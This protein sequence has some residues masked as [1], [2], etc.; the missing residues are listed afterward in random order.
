MNS[1]QVAILTNNINGITEL[2][3]DGTIEWCA[4]KNKLF[5]TLFKMAR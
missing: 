4:D 2:L 1:L 3:R 5:T